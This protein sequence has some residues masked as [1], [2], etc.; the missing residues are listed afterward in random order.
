ME[1]YFSPIN[2][3]LATIC[4]G[5]LAVFTIYLFLKYKERFGKLFF[6]GVF[7]QGVGGALHTLYWGLARLF[8]AQGNVELY[9]KMSNNI[10]FALAQGIDTIGAVIMI[11]CF[12]KFFI[13]K[14]K[15]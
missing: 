5:F 7:A 1:L 10:P 11:I 3:F 8:L 9:T 4:Y 13:K 15:Q 12:Y 14:H 2:Y 6:I